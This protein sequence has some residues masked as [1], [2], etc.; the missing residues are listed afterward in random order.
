MQ[1]YPYEMYHPRLRD[2]P[3]AGSAVDWAVQL[4]QGSDGSC[5]RVICTEALLPGHIIAIDRGLFPTLAVTATWRR[6]GQ[7]FAEPPMGLL[8]PCPGC[9]ATL[10]CGNRCVQLALA[11]FHRYECRLAGM[12]Q[13]R[14][15]LRPIVRLLLETFGDAA[16]V[17][18]MMALCERRK[19]FGVWLKHNYFA[20]GRQQQNDGRL[21]ANA[22]A[23]LVYALS[24]RDEYTAADGANAFHIARQ[25][26]Y[27]YRVLE[28]KT[29][30]VRELFDTAAKQ[31]FLRRYI[32]THMQILAVHAVRPHRM[33]SC[34]RFTEDRQS[35]ADA[36]RAVWPLWST[37]RHSCQPNVVAV[38]LTATKLALCA[39]RPIAANQTL[40]VDRTHGLH[41]LGDAV[42]KHRLLGS[43]FRMRCRCRRTRKHDA[44]SIVNKPDLASG[45][46]MKKMWRAADWLGKRDAPPIVMNDR[47][48]AAAAAATAA[49]SNRNAATFVCRR[50]DA[51]VMPYSNPM[52]PSLFHGRE[53]LAKL[54]SLA[55][56]GQLHEEDS[57][58]TVAER[59][60]K[61]S[62]VLAAEDAL[63]PCRELWM[64]GQLFEL[65][66]ERLLWPSFELDV[67]VDD[68]ALT[69][70]AWEVELRKRHQLL[71]ESKMP[72]MGVSAR[73]AAAMIGG[74][75]KPIDQQQSESTST[76]TF[77]DS[78][79]S[80]V[81]TVVEK[82]ERTVATWRRPDKVA[83]AAEVVV[84]Q[85]GTVDEPS[86]SSSMASA[87]T[88]STTLTSGRHECEGGTGIKETQPP[89]VRR[90]SSLVDVTQPS[91]AMRPASV[92]GTPVSCCLEGAL[93][94]TSAAD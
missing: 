60:T 9:S 84:E 70:R 44:Q 77:T 49:N 21:P 59:M 47:D 88:V 92:G 13:R 78:D 26:A 62:L 93:R 24:E 66:L 39:V 38:A 54:G 34:V 46:E 14:P 91:L 17:A 48:A 42:A 86:G 79:S 16:A 51:P 43:V 36:T 10:F 30:F 89:R 63:H 74:R 20:L 8:R 55:K 41:A 87:S 72:M 1:R 65:C 61:L 69:T 29:E 82:I 73:V 11:G 75:P 90:S 25:A 64:V 52:S 31:L 18:D 5:Q 53:M 23:K 27:L 57:M 37:L 50:H 3:F 4:R 2:G 15:A 67:G 12:L 81:E 68:F 85:Q 32:Y 40:T 35:A 76:R 7:C 83:A 33:S 56:Y 71:H 58:P 94:D 45:V 80:D 28:H 22:A 19:G 6:C